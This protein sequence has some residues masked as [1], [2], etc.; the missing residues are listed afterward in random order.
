M[1]KDGEVREGGSGMMEYR[2][3]R[4]EGSSG[5]TV[6]EEEKYVGVVKGMM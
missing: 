6:V 4:V 1:E 3:V 2:M 5:R